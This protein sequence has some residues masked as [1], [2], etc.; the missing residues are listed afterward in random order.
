MKY[1]GY[2]PKYNLVVECHGYQHYIFP[3]YF[4]K[5]E[6]Q[7]LHYTQLDAYKKRKILNKGLYF[8]A[9]SYLDDIDINSLQKKINIIIGG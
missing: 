7:W 2:F 1:D 9:I 5:T 6:K 8:M 3:N 4:N